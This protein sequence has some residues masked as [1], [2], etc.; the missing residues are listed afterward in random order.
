MRRAAAN[1]TSVCAVDSGGGLKV[2]TKLATFDK[3]ISLFRRV[4]VK[5][6]SPASF[7]YA[8][9]VAFEYLKKL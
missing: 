2:R 3:I 1:D 6:E 5:L 8:R 4:I 9:K 7:F